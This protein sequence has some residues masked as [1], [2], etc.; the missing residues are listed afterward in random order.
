[1]LNQIDIVK[2]NF[3]IDII[4]L[5]RKYLLQDEGINKV[6]FGVK[7]K[8]HVFDFNKDI[9]SEEIPIESISK[10]NKLRENKFNL[11]ENSFI[12]Y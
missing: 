12:S 7:Q 3:D 11:D 4:S 2:D 9:L 10:I 1:M 5:S 8:S 6:I